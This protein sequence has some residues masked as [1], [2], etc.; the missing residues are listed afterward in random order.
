MYNI[1]V[2]MTCY[3]ASPFIEDCIVSVLSQSFEDFEFVI[4]DDGSTDDTINKIQHFNDKRIRLI[5][6]DHNYIESLNLSVNKSQGKYLA[7][8]DAD[9]I[10]FKDRL[11]IQYNYLEHNKDIDLLAGGMEFFGEMEGIYIPKINDTPVS[12]EDLFENNIIGHPTVM[13]R[14]EVLQHLPCLYEQEYAYAE[15]YKLWFTMLTNNLK[16]DNI[17]D[18]LIKH[19]MSNTQASIVKQSEQAEAIRKIK[20]LYFPSRADS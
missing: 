1:S 3:N 18:I 19:R 7:K 11:L 4:V 17:P 8:M 2:F 15:D 6:N 16:L 5:H 12:M 9:D 14:K 20:D 13:M 10:M